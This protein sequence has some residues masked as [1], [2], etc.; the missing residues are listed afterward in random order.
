MNL[1]LTID[2]ANALGPVTREFTEGNNRMS[3]LIIGK[4]ASDYSD[5]RY[6]A[7]N[8]RQ[9]LMDLAI[10]G[11][12]LPP[13]ASDSDIAKAQTLRRKNQAEVVIG[14]FNDEL[15]ELG[16][17]YDKTFKELIG[18]ASTKAD[19]IDKL[20]AADVM[21]RSPDALK[22]LKPKEVTAIRQA[23]KDAVDPEPLIKAAAERAGRTGF[24]TDH[25][26]RGEAILASFYTPLSETESLSK[27]VKFQALSTK[28][29]EISGESREVRRG[30]NAAYREHG[31]YLDASTRAKMKFGDQP[32]ITDEP[33]RDLPVPQD[34]NEIMGSAPQQ[35]APKP[36]SPP[37][38]DTFEKE[39]A[40]GVARRI[41]PRQVPV[42]GP[43]VSGVNMFVPGT[44]ENR[45]FS[46]GLSSLP[47]VAGNFM[48]GSKNSEPANMKDLVGMTEK[49]FFSPK[50][51]IPPAIPAGSEGQVKQMVRDLAVRLG[52]GSA[53]EVD[54][55][56]IE[57][58]KIQDPMD[59]N[60]DEGARRA[61]AVRNML[62]KMA[63]RQLGIPNAD[64]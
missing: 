59:P 46:E 62:T 56:G 57:L 25:P 13:D 44:R 12:D 40:V 29:K 18:I 55:L 7:R 47:A 31:A 26:E 36:T 60:L 49:G 9:K 21:L 61:L 30:M 42:V 3:N 53:D 54:R 16:Q 5:K 2:Q 24:F 50:R 58:D 23:I 28:L 63:M 37:I 8:R 43:A 14:G 20:S 10:T 1:A 27:Q 22:W 17:E 34:P 39:G 35:P 19:V 48:F 51:L 52:I 41:D 4:M 6:E 15:D 33:M 64:Q 32:A 45:I 11:I 38:S